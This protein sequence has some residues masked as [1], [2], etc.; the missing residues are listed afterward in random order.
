MNPFSGGMTLG[1]ADA[2]ENG[3]ALFALFSDWFHEHLKI[4]NNSYYG[5]NSSTGG[6]I[7]KEGK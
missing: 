7:C 3:I 4:N 1:L 2:V 5:Y 6:Q